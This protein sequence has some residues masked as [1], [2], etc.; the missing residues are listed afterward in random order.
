MP[1]RVAAAEPNDWKVC[2]GRK[3]RGAD[4]EACP[5]G[6]QAAHRQMAFGRSGDHDPGQEALALARRRQQR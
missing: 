3:I 4:S 1:A 5:S 6:T 2:M